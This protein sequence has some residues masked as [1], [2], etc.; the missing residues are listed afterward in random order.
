LSSSSLD[1]S[2]PPANAT[3]DFADLFAQRATTPAPEKD[4]GGIQN[5]DHEP[6][7]PD[8][9][10]ALK[11]RTTSMRNRLAVAVAVIAIA[12]IGAGGIAAAAEK[13]G[14]SRET[15]VLAAR[16]TDV[17]VGVHSGTPN[18]PAP[19]DTFVIRQQLRSAGRDVG[20]A[21]ITCTAAFRGEFACQADIDLTGRGH[22][23]IQGVTQRGQSEL[24]VTGGTG[25]FRDAA[26]QATLVGAGDVDQQL[27]VHL[28]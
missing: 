21:I 19:G 6:G 13:D 4:D 3:H 2:A 26:G 7:P 28:G 10:S 1:P 8:T 15:I 17:A 9:P 12:G 27:T 5:P 22:I 18:M 14:T 20:A 23:E 16:Q 11:E 24:A 25:E